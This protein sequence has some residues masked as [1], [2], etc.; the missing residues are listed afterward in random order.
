MTSPWVAGDEIPPARLHVETAADVRVEVVVRAAW[1][2]V[3]VR[4]SDW[5]V[6]LRVD[7]DSWSHW[8]RL[9]E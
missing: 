2:E 9:D 1:E 7:S 6:P 3:V 5:P 8:S 4:V